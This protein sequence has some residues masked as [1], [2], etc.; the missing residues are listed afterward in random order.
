MFNFLTVISKQLNLNYV[1]LLIILGII[2]FYKAGKT[3]IDKIISFFNKKEIRKLEEIKKEKEKELEKQKLERSNYEV[4][5]YEGIQNLI[6]RVIETS[7]DR[8]YEFRK[9]LEKIDNI[10]NIILKGKKK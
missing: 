3:F 7:N 4:K 2:L 9:L 6:N 1:E 8:K 5:L 10:E